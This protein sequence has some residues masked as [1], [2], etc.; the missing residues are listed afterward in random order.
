MRTLHGLP[1]GAV[2][3][4]SGCAVLP[5]TGLYRPVWEY[6]ARTLARDLSAHLAYG[7]GTGAAFR[8]FAGRNLFAGRTM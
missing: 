8:L 7:M 3:W 1:F 5:A 6:D 4:A 2:V